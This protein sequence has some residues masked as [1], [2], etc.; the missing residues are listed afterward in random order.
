MSVKT[1]GKGLGI[2]GLT[3]KQSTDQEEIRP[4]KEKPSLNFKDSR[5]HINSS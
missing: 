4:L 3:K 5:V 1:E 2:Y